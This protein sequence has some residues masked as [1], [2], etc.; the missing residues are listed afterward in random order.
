MR[1]ERWLPFLACIT[2]GATLA[3]SGDSV[4]LLGSENEVRLR[5]TTTVVASELKLYEFD[6]A[7][8]PE[9][10]GAYPALG[11]RYEDWTVR[12]WSREVDGS[13]LTAILEFLDNER[14]KYPEDTQYGHVREQI[15]RGLL[16]PHVG[17]RTNAIV[18]RGQPPRPLD[19]ARP[20]HERAAG[21]PIQGQVVR[22]RSRRHRVAVIA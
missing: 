15:D 19:G 20:E 2:T 3:C 12:T 1:S 4:Q 18:D 22:G 5:S 16:D 9:V 14:G 21:S 10:V 11:P 7:V 8:A 6:G 17:G 13:E